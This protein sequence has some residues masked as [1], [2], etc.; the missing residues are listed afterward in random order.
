M[1]VGLAVGA[2]VAY[3]KLVQVRMNV[4]AS[5]TTVGRRHFPVPKSQ[6]GLV[7]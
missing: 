5:R 1:G 2:A 6:M 3:S 4:P 7:S